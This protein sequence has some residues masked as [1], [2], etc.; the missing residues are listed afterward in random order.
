MPQLSQAQLKLI[1]QY[2]LDRDETTS[3]YSA[4]PTNLTSIAPDPVARIGSTLDELNL[5]SERVGNGRHVGY[6]D[7]YEAIDEYREPLGHNVEHS[8]SYV[9]YCPDCTTR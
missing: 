6:E 8:C 4:A 1:V 9:S 7:D 2:A 3:V 5:G